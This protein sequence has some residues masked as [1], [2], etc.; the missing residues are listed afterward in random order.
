M[1]GP[2]IVQRRD[3]CWVPC[4]RVERVL[5]KPPSVSKW[6]VV[7]FVSIVVLGLVSCAAPRPYAQPTL[8]LPQSWGDAGMWQALSVQDVPANPEWWV[9]FNDPALTVLI[10]K[11]LTS[12][13]TL[14]IAKARVDQARAGLQ[15]A[16]SSTLPQLGA[17]GRVARLQISQYRPLNN[18][19]SPNWSTVQTDIA[20]LMS[21]SYELDLWGLSKCK[22]GA[23]HR[24]RYQLFQRETSRYR[25][26]SLKANC[27]GPRKVLGRGPEPL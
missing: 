6:A 9:Q 14:T 15:T 17:S 25:V 4:H 23:H 1:S 13:T 11:A 12:S 8:E 18:Y 7:G 27:A 5:A 10:Q 19:N 21:A 2:T 16:N 26:G 20:P 3:P 24:Y 22:V